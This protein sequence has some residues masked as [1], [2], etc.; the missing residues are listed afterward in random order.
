MA[1][2]CPQCKKQNHDILQNC[3]NC[4]Y[5]VGKG[6]VDQ[7]ETREGAHKVAED[8][9]IEEYDDITDQAKLPSAGTSLKKKSGLALVTI[10]GVSRTEIGELMQKNNVEY[11]FAEMP[12]LFKPDDALT[13]DQ[14]R[15][16][17]LG[18]Q[19]EIG[20]GSAVAAGGSG[21][22]YY[23]YG[24]PGMSGFCCYYACLP[25]GRYHSHH[26]TRSSSCCGGTSDC[27]CNDSGS[28]SDELGFIIILAILALAVAAFILLAPTIAVVGVIFI[29]VILALLIFGFNVI[30]LGLFRKKLSRT[31]VRIM[32]A[33]PQQLDRFF[34]DLLDKGGLPKMHGYWTSGFKG[35]RYGAQFFM[36]G[37]LVL[38]LAFLFVGLDFNRIYWIPVGIISLSIVTLIWG[39]FAIKKKI[40]EVRY[41]Y[42]AKGEVN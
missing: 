31:R 40:E 9:G 6:Y 39:N 32:A 14:E 16:Q 15:H 28:D 22:D 29:E 7:L 10:Y 41:K 4:G 2:Y 34:D 42:L 12:K 1:K 8:F 13:D 27:D 11:E 21:G 18:K 38:V 23:Y 36:V 25:S 37:L 26:S 19:P 5:W 35:M 33:E 20:A 17:M 30:T 3:W 24:D